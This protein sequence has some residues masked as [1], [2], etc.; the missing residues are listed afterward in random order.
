LALLGVVASWIVAMLDVT[1][2][3]PATGEAIRAVNLLSADGVRRMLT[4]AVANFT[5]FPPLGLVIVVIIGIAVAENSGLVAVALRRFVA[6]V[7]PSM[8][9]RSEERRVGKERGS[10]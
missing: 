6:S 9:T 8:L 3:H 5:A 10:R 2:V 7:P 4:G 1:A